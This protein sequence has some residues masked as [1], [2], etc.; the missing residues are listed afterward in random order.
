MVYKSVYERQD[1]ES[2]VQTQDVMELRVWLRLLTCNNLLDTEVRT[3]LKQ[4]AETTLPR[5]DILAQLERHEGPMSMGELSKRLMVSNGNVTGLVDRLAS[6]A[7]VNRRPSDDD[8]RVQMVSLTPRG[9]ESFSKMAENHRI[10][11]RDM[12]AGL[13]ADEI[14][15]L[16]ELLARL[17]QSIL[18]AEQKSSL[19]VTA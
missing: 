6:E 18:A 3:R 17:K 12:M 10:W 8:R 19:E 14:N 13:T 7:L 11:I 9:R 5:F 4:T 15:K 2:R 16:Y 1:Y